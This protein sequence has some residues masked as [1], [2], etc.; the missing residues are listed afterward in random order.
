MWRLSLRGGGFDV[1]EAMH[2]KQDIDYEYLMRQPASTANARTVLPPY[3]QQGAGSEFVFDE[4]KELKEAMM[5]NSSDT[6]SSFN[7]S[8]DTVH[9]FDIRREILEE[10]MSDAG[11]LDG[12]MSTETGLNKEATNFF[13][14]SVSED[15]MLAANETQEELLSRYSRIPDAIASDDD[16]ALMEEIQA[17]Y[18]QALHRV[19]QQSRKRSSTVEDAINSEEHLEQP[20]K[21]VKPGVDES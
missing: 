3:S 16:S 13:P 7:S 19:K 9:G 17:R 8:D 11:D 2:G 1:S 6:H 10:E 5:D 15:D 4:Y 18:G 14:I 12:P 20:H 21:K